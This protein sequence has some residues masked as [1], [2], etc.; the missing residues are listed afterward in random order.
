MIRSF[1]NHFNPF[2]V[3]KD[4]MKCSHKAKHYSLGTVSSFGSIYLFK[5][6]RFMSGVAFVGLTCYNFAMVGLYH[7]TPTIA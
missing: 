3:R 5:T 2:A 6:N 7:I 4:N 1:V